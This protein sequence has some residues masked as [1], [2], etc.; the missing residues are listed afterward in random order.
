M[1]LIVILIFNEI[2]KYLIM[3]KCRIKKIKYNNIFNFV[4]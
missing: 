3:F 1:A 4:N 2:K